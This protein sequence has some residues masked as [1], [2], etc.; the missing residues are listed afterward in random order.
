MANEKESNL[1]LNLALFAVLAA[2]D[3]LS[4]YIIRSSGGFYIC[5]KNLA[6]SIPASPTILYVL[7][8]TILFLLVTL[9]AKYNW[10]LANNNSKKTAKTSFPIANYSLLITSALP[11]ALI[12]SGGLSNLID[13]AYFGCVID[14]IDLGFWPVFNLAD[15]FITLGAILLIMQN[16][17]IKLKNCQ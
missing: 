16:I 8:I 10:K 15:I 3:Q 5:N 14:F 4:K 13:R 11:L 17:N 1:I 7:L 9:L 6:F 2:S 12:I